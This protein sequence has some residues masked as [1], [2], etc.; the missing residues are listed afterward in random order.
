MRGAASRDVHVLDVGR[1]PWSA[2]AAKIA[3]VSTTVTAVTAMSR[4]G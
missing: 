1:T 4:R 3:A 2:T